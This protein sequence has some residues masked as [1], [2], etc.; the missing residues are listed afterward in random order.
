VSI[1]SNCA[2]LQKTC[3]QGSDIILT[4][5]D[6]KRIAPLEITEKIAVKIGGFYER[7]FPADYDY[8]QDEDPNWDSYTLDSDR[9][10]QL[11]KK[12]QHGNCVFLGD[13]GCKLELEMRPV[14]CRI[15][16]FYYNEEKILELDPYKCP[17]GIV[18]NDDRWLRENLGVDKT[19][20][21]QW[22]AQFYKELK[23]G[24]IYNENRTNI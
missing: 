10:M 9:K 2:S 14:I 15:Y 4:D 11:M 19:M 23:E 1:C 13:A 21:D 16:P 7:R 5:N 12:N 17:S 6:I 8:G 18:I 3:C 24:N 22:R 20:A